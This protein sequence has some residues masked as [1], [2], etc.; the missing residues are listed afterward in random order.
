M[1]LLFHLMLLLATLIHSE[2]HRPLYL[3]SKLKN[4]P[5]LAQIN[6]YIP[7]QINVA[8]FFVLITLFFALLSFCRYLRN[9]L[10][11]FRLRLNRVLILRRTRD[12]RT[13]E[14]RFASDSTSLV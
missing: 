4:A 10:T 11:S 13:V 9:Y 5:T 2:G 14:I 1:T 3:T 7:V 8:I 6:M 12:L